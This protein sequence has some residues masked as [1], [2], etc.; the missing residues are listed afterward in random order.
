MG[1]ANID[2]RRN[3]TEVLQMLNCYSSVFL[4]PDIR[5]HERQANFE[6]VDSA[7]VKFGERRAAN[8]YVG[9]FKAGSHL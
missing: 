6:F 9:M 8:I 1:A 3:E 7:V 2:S 4:D 5:K